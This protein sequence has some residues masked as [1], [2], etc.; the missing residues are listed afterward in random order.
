MPRLFLDTDI[1]L[2]LVCDTRRFSADSSELMTMAVATDA[3][4]MAGVGSFKDVYYIQ[5]KATHD[6]RRAR[7]AMRLLRGLVEVVGL[8]EEALDRALGSD[9]PD[10]EDGMVRASAE[11]C[12]ADVI[13]THDEAAFRGSS[14]TKMSAGEVLTLLG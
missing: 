5:C 9:E 14:V 10:L 11:L 1:L 4:V 6:E 12:G 13:V 3:E 7:D 8:D 2:D